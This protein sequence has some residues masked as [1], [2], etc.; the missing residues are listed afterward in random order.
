MGA[1]LSKMSLPATFLLLLLLPAF[2]SCSPWG[3]NYWCGYSQRW[4]QS[5]A[6]ITFVPDSLGEYYGTPT[7]DNQASGDYPSPSDDVAHPGVEPYQPRERP[8]LGMS[9]LT[10]VPFDRANGIFTVPEN[11]FNDRDWG[12]PYIVTVTATMGGMS[13][14]EVPTMPPAYAQIFL[15]KAGVVFHR[16]PFPNNVDEIL[17]GVA[18]EGEVLDLRKVVTLLPGQTLQLVTGHV[19]T[20]RHAFGP[21]GGLLRVDGGAL[22]DVTLCIMKGV[23]RSG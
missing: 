1:S 5:D 7:Y 2:I 20:R 8:W 17:Y 16:G 12:G 4:G 15:K 11:G 3:P 10:R 21:S 14:R 6:I 13:R 9:N 22:W 18:K 19:V 23:D